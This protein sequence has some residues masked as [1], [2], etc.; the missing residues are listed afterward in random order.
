[1]ICTSTE[2]ADFTKGDC[3]AAT[4]RKLCEVQQQQFMADWKMANKGD[5]A[6][7]RNVAFCLKNTC[8]GAIAKDTTAG[9]S[10]RMIIQAAKNKKTE[11]DAWSYQADCGALENIDRKSALRKAETT[12]KRIYKRR[13]P[14]EALL[15]K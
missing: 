1:M 13:L 14:V 4:N 2:A 7:Q 8:D 15:R 3:A 5:Y 11:S 6:A 9:C 12:F 10:W